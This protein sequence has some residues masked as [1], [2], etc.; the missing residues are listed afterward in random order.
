[1]MNIEVSMGFPLRL[2][3]FLTAVNLAPPPPRKQFYLSLFLGFFFKTHFF[4]KDGNP[5]QDIELILHW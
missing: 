5:N 1:M 4:K 3:N 2:N